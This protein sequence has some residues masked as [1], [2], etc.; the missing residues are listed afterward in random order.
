VLDA[1]GF[2][3]AVPG[4]S[5]TTSCARPAHGGL[6]NTHEARG[7]FRFVTA[8]SPTTCRR[9]RRGAASGRAVGDRDPFVLAFDA[10]APQLTTRHLLFLPLMRIAAENSRM[11]RGSPDVTFKNVLSP[12]AVVP[13]PND[14]VRRWTTAKRASRMS[15]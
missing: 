8:A 12:L 13:T 15:P 4:S 11:G 5:T 9:V 3:S 1:I 7:V 10:F 14:F 2:S 6:P